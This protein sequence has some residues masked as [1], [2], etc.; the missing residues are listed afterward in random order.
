MKADATDTGEARKRT[1]SAMAETTS[2]KGQNQRVLGNAQAAVTVAEYSDLRCPDS[3]RACHE[4]FPLI[5]SRYFD[6]IRYELHAFPLDEH[7]EA[8]K[9]E[10]A[11]RAAGEQGKY[12]EYR[13]ALFNDL[14]PVTDESLTAKAAMV[15]VDEEA[16]SA[17][18]AND[19]HAAEV[20]REKSAAQAIGVRATPTFIVSVRSADGTRKEVARLKNPKS[21]QELAA[22]IDQAIAGSSGSEG[23]SG[24][25]AAVERM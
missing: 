13:T 20:Q 11:A 22:A 16:F 4:Y 9:A 6:K 18:M 5:E 25:A 24:G 2:S 10:A 15:G 14:T 3:A 19:K 23:K 1:E 7:P 21:F 8:P 12:L 17:A